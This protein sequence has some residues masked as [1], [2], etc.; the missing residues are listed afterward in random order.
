MCISEK[1]LLYDELPFWSAPFGLLLLETVRYKKNIRVLD[2]GSGSGFPTLELAGR[3]GSGSE[4]YG[5]DPSGDAIE[6]LDAKIRLREAGNAFAI[7]GSGESIPFGDAHFDLIISNNGL[8]NVDDMAGV[9]RECYRVCKPGGQMVLTM[10]L[11]YTMVEFYDAL[12]S[13][14]SRLGLAE[15]IEA[16]DAHIFEKRKPVDYLQVLILENGFHI[17]SVQ[18][19]G[20]KY[21]FAS[22]AAFYDHYLIRNFFLP[23]WKKFLPPGPHEQIFAETAVILDRVASENGNLEISVPFVC[24][25]VEKK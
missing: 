23:P 18:P 5:L 22:A 7:K 6:M 8:N 24:I 11:P 4:V 13:V 15:S 10:N 12:R 21:H 1:S 16:M 20:F 25:D 19:D 14:L 3:L 9:L 2:I 17:R